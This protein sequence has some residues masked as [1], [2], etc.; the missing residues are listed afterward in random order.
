MEHISSQ[1]MHLVV[2]FLPFLLGIILHEISH[3]FAALKCGDPTARMMG[4]LTLN[5]LPHIDPVGLG[6]FVVTSLF[7]PFVF[8]WAKPVPVNPRY[9]RNYRRDILLVSAAGPACNFLLAVLLALLLRLLL[10][11]PND[12]ILHS[13]IGNFFLQML[14]GGISANLVL[15]WFNLL[16]IPPLDGGHILQCLLPYRMASS[17]DRIGKTGF[18]ILVVLLACGALN[19]VLMPILNLSFK[20]MLSLAGI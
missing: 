4:R 8:G 10:L 14:L 2:V 9:F 1:L 7:T 20:A 15:G 13:N 5:P 19:Y 3:G 16:P 18:I 17:L 11:A 12:F 6:C